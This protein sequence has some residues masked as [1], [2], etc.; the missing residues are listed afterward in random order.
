MRCV[1][2]L[3][4]LLK[5]QVPARTLISFRLQDLVG[6]KY[7]LWTVIQ[8]DKGFPRHLIS[9]RIPSSHDTSVVR[10]RHSWCI[11]T[12]SGNHFIHT[13]LSFLRTNLPVWPTQLNYTNKGRAVSSSGGQG[14]RHLNQARHKYQNKSTS[15]GDLLTWV[16][17]HLL[18]YFSPEPE[19]STSINSPNAL[20]RSLPTT[21]Y[22]LSR[23]TTIHIY[24]CFPINHKKIGY[25]HYEKCANE[26]LNDRARGVK[27]GSECI[28]I[29][30]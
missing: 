29:C 21:R 3:T 7:L 8:Y 17:F 16:S 30:I 2:N 5:R 14:H 10:L 9:S 1:H 4:K 15:S 20:K 12:L 28:Y 25:I 18:V 27:T 13:Y 24:K 6:I 23:T 26:D 22:Q 19:S 11:I